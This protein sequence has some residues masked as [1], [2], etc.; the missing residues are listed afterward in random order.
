MV[1]RRVVCEVDCFTTF[2]KTAFCLCEAVGRGSPWPG[3]D[4]C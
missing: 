2:A 4:L 3:E 1:G